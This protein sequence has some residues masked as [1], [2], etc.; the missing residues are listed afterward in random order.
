MQAGINAHYL[1]LLDVTIVKLF[2]VENCSSLSPQRSS[3]RG[4]RGEALSLGLSG[5]GLKF[6]PD[7]PAAEYVA[8]IA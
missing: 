5:G 1:Y 2:G 4:Y 3:T 7:D 8:G 6:L